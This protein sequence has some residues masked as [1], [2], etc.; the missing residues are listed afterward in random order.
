[1]VKFIKNTLVCYLILT[2]FSCDRKAQNIPHFAISKVFKSDTLTTIDVHINNR[3]SAMQLLLIAGKLKTDSTLI[4]N[5]A[6]HY[7][8]PGNTDLSAGENSYYAAASYVK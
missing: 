5:L 1:M 2:F 4:Q 6:I 3:L 7:L 8:L